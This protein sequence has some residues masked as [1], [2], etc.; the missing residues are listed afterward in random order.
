MTEV[1]LWQFSQHTFNLK[2]LRKRKECGIM[3]RG[4]RNAKTENVENH[5]PRLHAAEHQP[6]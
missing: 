6:T 2:N 3:T 5:C 1:S 4:E